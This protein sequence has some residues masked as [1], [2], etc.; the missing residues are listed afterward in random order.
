MSSETEADVPA[1]QD[2]ARELS[3]STG[4]FKESV[5]NLRAALE[6]DEGCWSDDEIGK[7][8]AQKYGEA[9]E[10]KD[11]LKNLGESLDEFANDG[12]PQ[13]VGNIQQ[14]DSQFGDELKKFADQ[15]GDY[16]PTSDR[17]GGDGG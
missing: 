17:S 2:A 9:N 5:E 8:F 13:A 12:L 15:V 4:D 7:Q 1:V 11:N 14:L 3:R 16:K 10:I 6:R